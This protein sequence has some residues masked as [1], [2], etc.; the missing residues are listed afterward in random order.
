MKRYIFLFF[1]I[2]ILASLYYL[3]QQGK[4]SDRAL[5]IEKVARLNTTDS[6]VALTFDDGPS[7]ACTPLLLDLLKRHNI[8]ATFFVNG[9]KME[10]APLI[11][12]RI[13]REGHRVGNHTYAHDRMVFK[14][15]QFIHQDLLK[16]DSLLLLAGVTDLQYFRPPYGDTFI[17]L[18]LVLNAQKK[19][20]IGWD[21]NPNTQYEKP[22]RAVSVV[23]ETLD[24]VNIGS[25]IL[26]HDGWPEP[27][28]EFISAVEQII[29]ELKSKGYRFVKIDDTLL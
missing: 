26:L 18:P 24:Q 14:S 9:N 28:S 23:Q 2:S 1:L 15:R 29:L 6:I 22:F 21:V 8:K 12:K 16:T 3:R 17:Q 19:R 10:A 11:T 7:R 25:I 13:V 4:K 27:V 20:C 5:F